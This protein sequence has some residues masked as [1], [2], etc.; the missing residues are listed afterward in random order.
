MKISTDW[1]RS[2]LVGKRPSADAIADR[3]GRCGVEVE[4]VER[5]ADAL[6]GLVVAEVRS[7][8]PHPNANAL[9]VTRVFD[10]DA[11]RVV[12]CGA[13]N[14]EP[15]QK[16]ALA[17]P[18]VRLG[19]GLDIAVRSI[20]GV[21]SHGML[22][23][24]AELGLGS[25]ASGILVL[26]PRARPGVE[27]AI[28]LA[29]T[30]VLLEL[31][32]GPNRPDLLSHFG[33]AR[34][35]AALFALAPKEIEPELAEG[36][37]KAL[38]LAAV[39]IE[40]LEGCPRY[41]GRVIRGVKV[42]PSPAW[43]VQRLESLGLRSISNV[44]DATNL[45]LL[46]LGHPLHPFDLSKLAH[47]Q[48]IVRRAR[49][50]EELTTIDA[51]LRKLDP[52]D[53]VIADANGAV[54]IAGVMGGAGTEVSVTTT[55][56][57]LECAVFDP[58]SVRR[59]S[60][61]H[62]LHTE[63]SHRF[64][65]GVDAGAVQLAVDRC[66][67]LIHELA[68]GAIAKGT[69]DVGTKPAKRPAVAV[70][71]ER[72]SLV[73]GRTVEAKELR[74]A[75]GSLGFNEVRA[76]ASKKP[77]P[78]TFEV[79]SFRHD[80]AIEEDLIEEVARLSGF[81]SIPAIVP[82]G[83]RAVWTKAPAED[84]EGNIRE[85]LAGLGLYEHVSLS[86]V[87]P[88]QHEALGL[89]GQAVE[90]LNPL[91]EETSRM[92]LSILP[93][94]LRAV[95]HNQ[96]V[97]CTSLRLFELGRVFE[98][99]RTPASLLAPGSL[100]KG[101]TFDASSTGSGQASGQIAPARGRLPVERHRLGIVLRGRRWPEVLGHDAALVDPYDAKGLVEALLSRLG[102]DA[103]SLRWVASGARFL[104]PRSATRIA[105]DDLDLGLLGELHPDVMSSP[106]IALEGSVPIVAELDVDA[107]LKA[108]APRRTFAPIPRL[109][110][111]DRDLSFF[112]SKDALAE[113]IVSLA[114]AEAG[115]HLESVRVFDVYTGQG[116]PE[117]K[118]S[119]ALSL[120]FR[121]AERTL[122]D[123]EVDGA[124]GAVI[125][126]LEGRLGADVRKG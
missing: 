94:L 30:D 36:P 89:E 60:K 41:L 48:I 105:L 67:E 76:R 29:R 46:E 35:L 47:A 40:D 111:V 107:I 66:A 118:K 98:W 87:A 109:P 27:L 106:V 7:A 25:D 122:T 100:P 14:V 18:G 116:V 82:P 37:E 11:E 38:E 17:R 22:C 12:V 101:F 5:Q 124:L 115:A 57:L 24:K 81:E 86:F 80:V 78:L 77:R 23:S 103:A 32:S 15:G 53:L 61:R 63:A 6:E 19:N 65:R 43:V 90:L 42:G 8:E 104:H 51:K 52:T 54:A 85:I 70:R 3:L 114:R 102:V 74:D 96:A 123:Q 125:R 9:K 73:L 75:L 13:P 4:G 121:A 79:P 126:A 119:L 92:R 1:V 113:G 68:G 91:G 2:L 117:G 120:R 58:R 16:V 95:R 110:P 99:E 64:E 45:A 88:Q 33:I 49:V 69:I 84:R 97:M 71:P 62:A 20:R 34:E 59:T 26:S 10:G 112:V 56:V 44:V 31:S 50:G 21:E 72:A 28:E 83:A 55:D 108:V 93:G 39:T